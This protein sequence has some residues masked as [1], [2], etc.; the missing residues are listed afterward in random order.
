[1]R[2]ADRLFQLINLLRGNRRAV[3]AR[4]LA[5]RL[6]VSERTIYRDVQALSLSNVPIEG[7]AGVGYRLQKQYDL[8]PLMFDTSEVEALLFGARMV[9]AWSDKQL[10]ASAHSAM[11]K[12]LA[13]LP[14]HLQ[15]SEQDTSLLVP[16]FIVD[17]RYRAYSE[18]I[19]AA[20]KSKQVLQLDYRR[21]DMEFSSRRIQP[22]G[23]FFWGRAWTVIGWCELRQAYRMFRLD[24]I[25]NLEMTG[26]TFSLS[27]EKNIDHYL[28]QMLECSG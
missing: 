25:A 6:Q 14:D 17:A 24:R 5:E 22:L 4:H 16:D 18:E 12:I 9:Q 13:I 28:Q 23:L 10:A 20:I 26:I 8:P 1:M 7:E 15:R 21:E 3:T 2:R 27:K 11:Q 19:R